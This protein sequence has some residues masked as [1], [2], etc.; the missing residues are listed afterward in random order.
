[1]LLGE[2]LRS[3]QGCFL[4]F[5]KPGGDDFAHDRLMLSENEIKGLLG[6]GIQNRN[7]KES[8]VYNISGMQSLF[9]LFLEREIVHKELLTIF[10][11]LS[12]IFEGLSEYLLDGSD[13]LLNPEYIFVNMEGELFFILIPGSGN[14]ISVCMR[15]LAL[16]LIKRTDHRDEQAVRDAYDFHKRVFA[17]DFSTNRYF[18]LEPL[19]VQAHGAAAREASCPL[20]SGYDEAEG[21]GY[22]RYHGADG[23]DLGGYEVREQAEFSGYD[24][25]EE[26]EFTRYEGGERGEAE[27]EKKSRIPE[28]GV[29]ALC[30]AGL[31]LLGSFIALAAFLSPNGIGRI[32][33]KGE[34]V[35]VSGIVGAILVLI[36]AMYS[37]KKARS[38]CDKLKQPQE[39]SGSLSD[40]SLKGE[41]GSRSDHEKRIYYL[42]G[43]REGGQRSIL[44]EEFPIIIGKAADCDG[45]IDSDTVSRHHA[46]IDKKKGGCY[47]TDLGSTNGTCLN[48]TRL[49]PHRPELLNPG[50]EILFADRKYYWTL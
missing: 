33:Y 10:K 39:G 21:S 27:E 9:E 18:E 49:E 32:F 24:E 15:E 40:R 30:A 6:F 43:D 37:N 25:A 7:G 44:P 13:L 17:G 38:R 35:A 5:E 47:L 11:G 36:P 46:R 50:D 12:E 1:M 8:F 29:Y 14:D 26:S 34:A 45:M 48:G 23:A 41:K 16:F 22:G 31:I 3:A 28:K 4:I 19:Y 42:S 20:Y 2:K